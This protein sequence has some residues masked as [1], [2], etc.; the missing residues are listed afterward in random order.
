MHTTER[1]FAD[2]TVVL[3]GSGRVQWR[4]LGCRGLAAATGIWPT[5]AQ[6]AA[7]E[8][9]LAVGHLLVVV[10][11]APYASVDLMPEEVPHL[12][13]E[14]LPELRLD[15][16]GF[17]QL[18]VTAFDWMPEAAAACGHG[19]LRRAAD[20]RSAPGGGL[21]PDLLQQEAVTGQVRFVHRAGH[22]PLTP[23]QLA[24]L[25]ATTRRLT[26]STL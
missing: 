12:A 2:V 23:A 13:A 17:G 20:L 14:L 24:D 6:R 26:G 3:E 8:Q 4:P 7:L 1:S 5:P 15:P 18:R 9:R 22:R 10:A 19:F 16:D 21:L 11:D 25:A